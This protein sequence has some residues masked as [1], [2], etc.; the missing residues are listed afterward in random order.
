MSSLFLQT[1][2]S[3]LG[4]LFQERLLVSLGWHV[5]KIHEY[6][7]RRLLSLSS[8]SGAQSSYPSFTNLIKLLCVQEVIIRKV[9]S[10]CLFCLAVLKFPLALKFAFLEPTSV[11]MSF[12][13]ISAF[14][15]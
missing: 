14:Q 1:V 9:R 5:E 12:F 2:L 10:K 13:A 6:L 3:E 15:D 8:R 4:H 11:M 7:R